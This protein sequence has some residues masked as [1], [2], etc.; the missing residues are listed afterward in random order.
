MLPPMS[1]SGFVPASMAS[2]QGASPSAAMMGSMMGSRPPPKVLTSMSQVPQ[3]VDQSWA[4]MNS[5]TGAGTQG[6]MGTQAFGTQ[7]FGSQALGTQA[8]GSQPLGSGRVQ[9][10]GSQ[11]AMTSS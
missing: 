8:F 9:P 4:S 10:F 2:A 6:P 3:E 7:A 1:G 5:S 11:A